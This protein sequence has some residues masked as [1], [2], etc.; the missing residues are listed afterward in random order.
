MTDDWPYPEPPDDGGAMHLLPGRRLPSI[1]LPST[2]GAALD[3][4]GLKGGAVLFIYPWTG[5][6]GVE[7][8]PDW[9]R[10]AGAH[11][12]TPEAQ[13]FEA[14]RD[15]FTRA[16][17]SIF[18]LSGQSNADQREFSLRSGLSYPLLSDADGRLRDALGLPTFETGGVLYLRR[19]TLLLRD[20][21]ILRALYPVHPPHTHAADVLRHLSS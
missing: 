10:I 5:R 20:G 1:A 7:N 4:S 14:L 17:F 15:Q 3:V 6:P 12:S 21:V 11:G 19:L 8:P 13:G 9:D 2:V 16:G 18:G